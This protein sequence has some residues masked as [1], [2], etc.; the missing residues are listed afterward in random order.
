MCGRAMRHKDVRQC[1]FG[2][3]GF[4]LVSRFHITGEFTGDKAVD[5]TKNESWFD[6]KL[7]VDC[8]GSDEAMS[9]PMSNSTYATCMSKTLRHLGIASN[10]IVHIGR[11][12]GAGE[13]QL[14]ENEDAGT[15]Q[16]GNWGSSTRDKFYSIKLP[17]KTMRNGAGHV[18]A[19]GMFFMRR[20]TMRASPRLKD[21]V[22]P[23]VQVHLP[24]LLDLA[25]NLDPKK[26]GGDKYGT[27]ISFLELLD[28]LAEVV[29]QDAA[30][31]LVLHAE[32]ADHALFGLPV[33]QSAEFKISFLC[34][35]VV[36][37]YVLAC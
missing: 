23:F 8:F 21:S 27:A 17:L 5:W 10:K 29:L 15:N 9:T 3:L 18:K 34:L 22:F 25:A 32:R 2:G 33:F 36:F 26:E 16:M 1:H 24:V 35:I 31:M 12:F 7:L 4:Y 14:L 6:V 13:L 37:V 30:A 20:S 11:I 19:G 28:C